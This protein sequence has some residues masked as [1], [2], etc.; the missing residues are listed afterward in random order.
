MARKT[1]TEALFYVLNK[2]KGAGLQA[3][4]CISIKPNRILLLG[5]YYSR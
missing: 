1:N 3:G 5:K 4:P 2:I